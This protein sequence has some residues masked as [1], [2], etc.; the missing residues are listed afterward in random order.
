MT[1]EHDGS[2][3]REVDLPAN[4]LECHQHFKSDIE[5]PYFVPIPL[6]PHVFERIC[7]QL[8]NLF[9]RYDYDADNG[10]ITIRRAF[11]LHDDFGFEFGLLVQLEIDSILHGVPKSPKVTNRQSR[12][13]NLW[14]H[15][16]AKLGQECHPDGQFKDDRASRPGL[17]YEV[18]YYQTGNILEKIAKDYILGTKGAVTTVV[19]FNLK[20]KQGHSNVSIW[21]ARKSP[22]TNTVEAVCDLEPTMFQDSDG[23][24]VNGDKLLKLRLTDMAKEKYSDEYPLAPIHI[25]FSQLSRI[26]DFAKAQP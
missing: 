17:I 16:K 22:A 4:T 20:Y 2:D 7:P 3:A 24:M 1:N 15:D 18:G 21:R 26:F 25:P 13:V 11:N 9:R 5:G 14:E 23:E 6:E 10:I 8:D 19:C 12:R